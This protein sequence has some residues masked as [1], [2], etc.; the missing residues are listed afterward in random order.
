MS[1][2]KL[3]TRLVGSAATRRTLHGLCVGQSPPPPPRCPLRDP[4][5]RRRPRASI[6]GHLARACRTLR[7]A[8]RLAPTPDDLFIASIASD[9]A[10][11]AR[12]LPPRPRAA[13]RRK[14]LSRMGE[15]GEAAPAGCRRRNV[16]GPIEGRRGGTPRGPRSGGVADLPE[17]GPRVR[18]LGE[19]GRAV[20]PRGR[21]RVMGVC[22]GALVPRRAQG[23]RGGGR[24]GARSPPW[25]LEERRGRDPGLAADPVDDE[26]HLVDVA[27]AP[28]LAGLERTDDRVR[29][30][31]G[32]RRGVPVG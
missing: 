28:V 32:V 14:R 9:L 1:T 30:G 20:A 10:W 6:R 2:P 4:R 27:P 13:R 22:P 8:H 31:V 7:L 24:G 16:H 21:G 17:P 12:R 26:R 3:A 15:A 11:S 25:V 5:A 19:V 18:R 23:G 29:R